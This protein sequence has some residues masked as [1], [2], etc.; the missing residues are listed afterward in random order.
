MPHR[1]AVL[2][3]HVRDRAAIGER[4]LGEPV[5]EELDELADDALFSQHLVTVRTRSVAVA[6][7][8]KAVR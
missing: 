5:A 6:P 1:R 4:Q 3:R 2:G 8:G 7:F